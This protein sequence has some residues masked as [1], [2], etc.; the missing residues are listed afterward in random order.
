MK[1]QL[2]LLT[3]A[4]VLVFGSFCFI[5]AKLSPTVHAT[6]VE[7]AIT[8][9]TIWTLVDSPFVVSK[10]IFIYPNS[11]LTVEP[12]VEVRFG[13]NFAITVS[14][15][16]L[17]DGTNGGITFTS[18]RENA[19]AGNWRAL[20]FV[21]VQRST[22]VNCY[23]VYAEN[24]ILVENGSV[25]V[26]NSKI[27]QCSENGIA[28]TN[29]Q[30]IVDSCNISLCAQNGI[31]VIDSRL[32]VR[33]STIIE[34]TF[35]GVNMVGNGQVTAKENKIIANKNGVVIAGN[36]TTGVNVSENT[37]ST[38]AE[39]GIWIAADAHSNVTILHN[40]VSSNFH[41]FHITSY[42]S[43]YI[44]NNSV[45]YNNVGFFY[46]SGFH[47]VSY[48]D[49]YGNSIGMNVSTNE[50]LVINAEHN[51]WGASDGPYHVS[52][53]PTGNGN[54]V[55]GN[56]VNLDFI[57][58]LTR[59]FGYI[60]APPTA[61]LFCDKSRVSQNQEAMFFAT[62]SIDEGHIDYYKFD[63]GDGR[64]S[65]WTTL[66]IFTHK[67]SS[68][69][70]RIVK[71]TV[72]DD[73]GATNQDNWTI[74]VQSGLSLLTVEVIINTSDPTVGEGQQAAVLAYVRDSAGSL[75]NAN[76]TMFAA[77]GGNFTRWSGLTN[78]SGYF[79]TVF[80]APDIVQPQNVRVI[81]SA[82]LNGYADNSD[83]TYLKILP[84]LSV[85]ITASPTTVKS[86]STAQITVY[87][88][89][90]DQPMSNA[91]VTLIA[92]A[93]TLSSEAGVTSSDGLFTV[94]LR[95]PLATTST[96]V[97]IM[98]NATK[99]GYVGSAGQFTLT[100]TPKILGVHVSAEPVTLV[101]EAKTTVTVY[102]EYETVPIEGAD[103]TITAESGNLSTAN[104]LTDIHGDAN[105]EF[106]APSVNE[107][108]SIAITAKATSSGYAE[109][110][111]Q[112]VITVDPKTF[113]IIVSAVL[114]ATRA[115]TQVDVTVYVTCAEDSKPVADALVTMSA[116]GGNFS[117]PV[118]TTNA[119]GK[120]VFTFTAPQTT[121]QI[122]VTITA[123][124][125]RNGYVNGANQTSMI[126]TPLPVAPMEG[127]WP[128]TTILLILI[129]VIIVVVVAVLVKL[130]IIGFSFGGEE[131]SQE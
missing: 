29:G 85:Q 120:C 45:A 128:I 104:K 53:N 54:P 49:I 30:V 74:N 83:Y 118:K 23:V 114:N 105:F 21:G 106:T 31:D 35:D 28:A 62:N 80:T 19:S 82:S 129:P 89:S 94:T 78:S 10:D 108:S 117:L 73:F 13:D 87:V 68:T 125:T 124:V 14:G 56:G 42:T 81:A 57:F 48:N 55:G 71:V 16:L 8:Q 103:V 112:M 116:N 59:P 34:N 84:Q 113:K 50:P 70:S 99:I 72:M 131:A 109:N 7:G 66:S 44:T 12:N 36:M 90:N 39:N 38:N 102:V 11:T 115:G 127:G 77:N 9:D 4:L 22:L 65:S 24:G 69:G 33:N 3:T 93:G 52:L 20:N 37:I 2:K 1:K 25:E 96:D 26:K 75:E 51:Y 79:D 95:A 46:G 67:Y 130:K 126:I 123:N 121:V 6:Y 18:N 97:A 17:A 86:E 110:Q 98:A 88:R 122:P 27:T 58:F 40:T 119:T 32:T 111:N 15:K 43:T 92:N 41:G 101:S 61:V 63:F 107:S 100:V 5:N 91:S 47:N 64:T 60:N 76:V